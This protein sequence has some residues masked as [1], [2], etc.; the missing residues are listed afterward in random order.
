MSKPTHTLTL[1]SPIIRDSQEI[2]EVELREPRAGDLRGIK[3]LDL[4]QSDPAAVIE[5]LPRIST[6]T[7]YKHEVANFGPRDTTESIRV[8]GEMFVDAEGDMPGKDDF[9]TT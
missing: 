4:F 8:L 5:L 1:K 3:L 2:H 6:P 9:P 7:L